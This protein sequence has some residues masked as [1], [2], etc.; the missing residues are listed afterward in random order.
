MQ[1]G[2]YCVE[3]VEGCRKDGVRIVLL[4]MEHLWFHRAG[5]YVIQLLVWSASPRLVFSNGTCREFFLQRQ[6]ILGDASWFFIR[7]KARAELQFLY[8]FPSPML[9]E[10][11]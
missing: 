11:I 3:D 1:G 9:G 5:V 2:G 8:P 7:S 10:Y 6:V 4:A